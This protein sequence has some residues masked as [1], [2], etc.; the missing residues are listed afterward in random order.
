MIL[1]VMVE[2]SFYLENSCLNDLAVGIHKM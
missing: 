1:S 2:F